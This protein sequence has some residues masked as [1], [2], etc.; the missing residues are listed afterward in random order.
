[1]VL[2]R[3]EGWQRGKH[4]V[5]RLFKEEGLAFEK[6]PQRRRKAGGIG[7]SGSSPLHRIR[8]G[9]SISF[10]DQLQD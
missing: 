6:R 7:K 2:L 9:F 5:D 8:L 3:R 10:A 4:L 1:L